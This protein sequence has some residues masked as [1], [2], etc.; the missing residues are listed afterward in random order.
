MAID[1]YWNRFWAIAWEVSGASSEI[2]CESWLKYA[3]DLATIPAFSPAERPLAQALVWNRVAAIIRDDALELADPDSMPDM[4]AR[5]FAE[6]PDHALAERLKN[7]SLEALERSLGLAPGS[8]RHLPLADRRAQAMAGPGRGGSGSAPP[9]REV[10]GRPGNADSPVEF[11]L[12]TG[13]ARQSDN[14]CFR[15]LVLLNR[16]TVLYETGKQRFA[17]GCARQCA[18]AGR[19]DEGREQF[20][21]AE[22]LSPNLREE[23][24]YLARRALFEAKAGQP[25]E[26]DRFQREAQAALPEPAPLWLALAIES[27]RYQMTAATTRGYAALWSA[28]LKK[29]VQSQTAGAMAFLVGAYLELDVDYPGRDGQIEQLVQYLNRTKRLNYRQIDIE[30]VCDFLGRVPG[31]KGKELLTKLLPR[32][33]AAP[34]FG[35]AQLPGWDRGSCEEFAP[36]HPARSDPAS[37]EG[38]PVG[39]VIERPARKRNSC[40]PSRMR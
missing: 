25:D 36:V 39:R 40:R 18:V 7:K 1:P 11:R 32:A 13:T 28:G 31:Q 30:R 33:Q 19:W 20:R 9:A 29:K 14:V 34:G 16:S 22:E 26:S 10:P 4:F 8:P 3:R 2:A 24:T 21:A 37:G 27:A 17:S 5:K 12:Q 38:T 35:A 15:R 6:P 23:Y